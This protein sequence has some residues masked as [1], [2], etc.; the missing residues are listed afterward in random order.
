MHGKVKWNHSLDIFS[1]RVTFNLNS[2]LLLIMIY[3]IVCLTSL[4]LF[5]TIE[6]AWI[7]LEAF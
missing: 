4:I 7:K 1:H 6:F 5:I 3:L 2:P